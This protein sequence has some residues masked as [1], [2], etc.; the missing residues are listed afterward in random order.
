MSYHRGKL[1]CILAVQVN[2]ISAY[3]FIIYIYCCLGQYN[4][5]RS[6]EEDPILDTY[7]LINMHM[8]TTSHSAQARSCHIAIN[9][10][11]CLS[12]IHRQSIA[13]TLTWQLW[14]V[15]FLFLTQTLTFLHLPIPPVPTDSS[16]LLPQSKAHHTVYTKEMRIFFILRA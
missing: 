6:A 12:G 14:L 1:S 9:I 15:Q 8:R 16:G 7:V 13:L 10:D 4:Q 11:W 2:D 3:A 5:T